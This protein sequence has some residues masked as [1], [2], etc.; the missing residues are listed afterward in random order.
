MVVSTI[1][2]ILSPLELLAD[3]LNPFSDNFILKKIIDGIINIVDV[4]N[5]FSD[6]FILKEVISTIGNILSYINP[7]SEN[8]FAYK[9]LELLGELLKSL[10][11]PSEERLTAIS[12]AVSS[13]F[14]FVTSIKE[15]INGMKNMFN[16][17]GTAPKL[18]IE[19]GATKWT[20]K[21]TLTILDLSFYK[22]FKPLGDLMITGF[23]YLAF[24][25]RMLLMLPNIISGAG[26][27]IATFTSVTGYKSSDFFVKED[28]KDGR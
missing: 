6:N 27:G 11:I 24:I 15:A 22:P 14:S 19:V 26:G 5:P 12:D 1:K 28:L 25:W 20:E 18:Q 8:F 17:L 21:Q 2:T 7:F 3:W 9:L 16:N 10:F 23:C 4:L 13:K